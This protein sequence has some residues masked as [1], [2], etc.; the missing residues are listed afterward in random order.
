MK[1]PRC[2]TWNAYDLYTGALAIGLKR[3]LGNNPDIGLAKESFLPTMLCPVGPLKSEQFL[4]EKC[5]EVVPPVILP[6]E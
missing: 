1:D 5:T 4:M 6:K 2:A 3:E